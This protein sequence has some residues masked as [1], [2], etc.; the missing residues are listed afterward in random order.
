MPKRGGQ[1][2]VVDALGRAMSAMGHQVVVLAPR[3]RRPLKALDKALP[4]AVVRHPRF[5]STHK[6]VSWYRGSLLRLYRRE[7]FDL[8]HCHGIYPPG[9][10]A[11]LC[12]AAMPV[13]VVVTNH[14]GGLGKENVRLAK[15]QIRGRYLEA[16]A[17]A[18]VLVALS[19]SMEAEYRRL[20]P[21]VR[22]IVRIPNGVDIERWSGLHKRPVGLDD[23]VQAGNYILYLGRLR[24]RKG[25]DCLLAAFAKASTERSCQL[26]IAGEGDDGPALLTQAKELGL[27]DR[28]CFVGWVDGA[29]KAY[30]LQNALFSVIPSRLD[31]AFGLVAL[32]SYAAGRAVA[33]SAVSGLKELVVDGQTGVLFEPDSVSALTEA[34]ATMLDDSAGVQRM[35]EQA[36]RWVDK[37]H[38]NRVARR[39]L[40]LYQA[41]LN[42][43]RADFT[44]TESGAASRPEA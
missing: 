8:L 37:F 43:Q 28:C 24:V 5:Y 26:V 40:E 29:T 30:L 9:Y 2:V 31:E 15:R 20:C 1:E 11:A 42:G 38:W 41:L 12:R 23:R 3:P 10:I 16:L 4:Y 19:E 39:H 32:E 36:R 27:A 14:E 21:A 33:G 22:S 44:V 25:V 17:Q 34:L 7:G 35:G 18:D 13:P 6:F